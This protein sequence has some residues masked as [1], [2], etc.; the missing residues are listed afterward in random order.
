MTLIFFGFAQCLDALCKSED[1]SVPAHDAQCDNNNE[2]H[3]VQQSSYPKVQTDEYIH[4]FQ[5]N[6]TLPTV[7]EDNEDN[8]QVWESDLFFRRAPTPTASISTPIM[9]RRRAHPLPE[10]LDCSFS[11]MPFTPVLS[12]SLSVCSS[13]SGSSVST[14]LETLARRRHSRVED[15]VRQFE[16]VPLGPRRRYSIAC[17]ANPLMQS[18][19]PNI[20]NRTFGFQPVVGTWEK[21]IADARNAKTAGKEGTGRV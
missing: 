13:T 10:R 21:R 5:V 1:R 11:N 19:K 4:P 20:R 15:M 17:D 7:D 3:S 2:T 8:T 9:G 12:P 16:T 18:P 6:P 14:E